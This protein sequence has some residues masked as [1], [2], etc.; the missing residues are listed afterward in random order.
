MVK[1]HI[2]HHQL[3]LWLMVGRIDEVMIEYEYDSTAVRM[4]MTSMVL[5]FH[6]HYQSLDIDVFVCDIE[7]MNHQVEV[8]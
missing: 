6:S 8:L 1:Q 4:L 7:N 5:M 2:I 3:L